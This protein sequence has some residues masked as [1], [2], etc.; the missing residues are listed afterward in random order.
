MEGMD[1]TRIRKLL[2]LP[3]AAEVCMV[4]SA[5]KR[6]EKGIDVPQIRFEKSLFIFEV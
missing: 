1:A 2:R 3:R 6:G 5:G 4:I